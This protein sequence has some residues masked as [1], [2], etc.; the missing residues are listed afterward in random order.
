M[1]FSRG[2]ECPARAARSWHAHPSTSCSLEQALRVTSRGRYAGAGLDC[3]LRG[4]D[5]ERKT[6]ESPFR[7]AEPVEA[8]FLTADCRLRG[9]DGGARRSL[10]L[11][12]PFDGEGLGMR[13]PH[14]GK[15][16]CKDCPIMAL[17]SRNRTGL[18]P[19]RQ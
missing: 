5:G 10:W 13:F 18:P 19:A 11:P 15:M 2:V 3:R 7:Q 1:R 12:S 14:G 16:P 9:N 17:A 8:W 4:N 6:R